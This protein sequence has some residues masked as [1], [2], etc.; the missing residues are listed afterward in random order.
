MYTV[1]RELFET[2]LETLD[3]NCGL[4]IEP[5]YPGR[6]HSSSDCIAITGTF[7]ALAVFLFELGRIAEQ[8]D[9]YELEDLVAAA[10]W[11]TFGT[12]M[13]ISFPGWQFTE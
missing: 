5:A 7:P 10:A 2:V 9:N 1:D 8:S 13:V 6:H 4:A 11:N 12:A 3:P